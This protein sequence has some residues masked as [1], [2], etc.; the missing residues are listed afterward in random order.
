[1]REGGG[2]GGEKESFSAE[3]LLLWGQACMAHPWA[4]FFEC[5]S[6]GDLIGNDS[7]TKMES[8]VTPRERDERERERE[9]EEERNR[10]RDFISEQS[11]SLSLSLATAAARC[12]GA[13]PHTAILGGF[14][15]FLALRY[16]RNRA[17]GRCNI[18]K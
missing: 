16:V 7:W 17:R 8:Q 18:Y 14:T 1:V 5:F 9:K 2:G 15:I 11:L 4:V 6:V 13:Q 10:G 12:H 3:T